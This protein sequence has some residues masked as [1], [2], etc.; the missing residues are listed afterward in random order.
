MRR[1]SVPVANKRITTLIYAL[2]KLAWRVLRPRTKGVKVMLFNAAGE[3][4]LIRNT[5]GRTD[6]LVLPGGGVRPFE[7]PAAAAIRE[8]REELGLSVADLRLRSVHRSTAEG[9]RDQIYVFQ[10][11]TVGTPTLDQLEVQEALL[12]RPDA[13]PP[14]TSPATRRRIEEYIGARRADGCW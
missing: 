7:K 8:V 11:R 4:I 10:G 2:Q 3:I 6:L 14:Q 13:I 1:R 12:F 9:K 5:Y